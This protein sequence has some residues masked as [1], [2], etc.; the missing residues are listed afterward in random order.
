MAIQVQLRRGS[1]ADVA[2]NHGAQG[3]LWVDTTNNRVVV[4]DGT[5]NGG[6]PAAKL[7]EVPVAPSPNGATADF[8]WIEQL[9][10]CS[11]A[12][13]NIPLGGTYIMFA[14]ALRVVTAVTGAAS[15][16][17]NDSQNGNGHWGSGIGVS[18]GTTN[19][20]VASPGPY[21]N[22]STTLALAAVGGGGSFTGGTVRVSVLAMAVTPPS[23]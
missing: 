14:V 5:T 15:I 4:Q 9:I 8:Q 16:T 6:F 19:M 2:A 21:Y 10:T 7:S 22:G 13:V 20:G 23:S 18:A 11:G 17:I 3:E 1:S 12:T